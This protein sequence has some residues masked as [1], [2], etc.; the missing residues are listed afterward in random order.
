MLLGDDTQGG[1]LFVSGGGVSCGER[2][3]CGGRVP[4][5]GGSPSRGACVVEGTTLG[6][7]WRRVQTLVW[8]WVQAHK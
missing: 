4:V 6:Q 7:S 1:Y 3:V 8:W 5:G 2:P